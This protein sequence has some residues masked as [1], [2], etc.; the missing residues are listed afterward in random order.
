MLRTDIMT[1]MER[2]VFWTE[3]L[4]RHRG[5]KWMKPNLPNTV[6]SFFKY[7]CIDVISVL[8]AI[9]TVILYITFKIIYFFWRLI[10]EK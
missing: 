5:A 10:G 8:T 2:A 9:L 3:Y 7:Y 4:T 6:S 1:S